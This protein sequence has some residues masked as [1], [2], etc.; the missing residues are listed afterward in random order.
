MWV[1]VGAWVY[2]SE[3]ASGW[4]LSLELLLDCSYPLE[5]VSEL[6][7]VRREERGR[8]VRDVSVSHDV[9]RK[10]KEKS[11]SGGGGRGG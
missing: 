7:L 6:E 5:H 10:G 11:G 3:W 4:H 2:V 9:T 8:R 1:S